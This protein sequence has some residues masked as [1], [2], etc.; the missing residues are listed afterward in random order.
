MNG[1]EQICEELVRHGVKD[2]FGLLGDGNYRYL[3]LAPDRGIAYHPA[4]HETAA[5]AMADA[6]ARTTGRVGVCTVTH[7]PG[8]T[9]ALSSL[10]EVRR[11]KSPVLFLA[12][13]TPTWPTA[14]SCQDVDQKAL[15][16]AIGLRTERIR[17]VGTVARDLARAFAEV[18]RSGEPMALLIPTDVQDAACEYAP[19]SISAPPFTT[20]PSDE[21]VAHLAERLVAA[22]RPLLLAGRGA[23]R[24]DARDVLE[25]LAAHADM[26]L[27]TSALATGLFA[28]NP[29]SLGVVGGYATPATRAIIGQ[30]DLVIAFGASFS[31][32]TTLGGRIFSADATLVQIDRDPAAIGSH[33]PVDVGIVAD[34]AG[35]AEA[36]DSHVV[37]LRSEPRDS[38]RSSAM[39][40]RIDAARRIPFED[41]GTGEHIDPRTLMQRLDAMLP[42][43]RTITV[44]GGWHGT[45]PVQT[46]TVPD[47]RGFVFSQAYQC[48]GI[49]LGAAVGAAVGRPDRLAVL[50][51]GDGGLSMSLGEL[52]TAATCGRPVLVVVL[53]DNA[54]AAEVEGLRWLGL[55]TDLAYLD[56][57]SFAPVAEALGGQGITVRTV[58][59]LAALQQWLAKPSGMYLLDCRIECPFDYGRGGEEE[60]IEHIWH[61]PV[62]RTRQV[63]D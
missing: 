63:F 35:A 51:M 34:V 37:R 31:T 16:D 59:D 33:A 30:A 42:P 50:V 55:P 46:L 2:V 48:V 22:R 11:S 29:F 15:L 1:S 26:L 44:D 27:G 45:L 13:D 18:E 54:Y 6:Y 9:H 3:A 41:A 43:Q 62:T 28:S 53:N 20:A 40:E 49:G 61:E 17:A 39:A 8:L 10:V 36:L 57:L 14:Y 56:E 60:W 38:Q 21:D 19:T 4:R 52:P 47:A 12:S 23:V 24:P 7:G 25:R 58:D 5:I 32:W